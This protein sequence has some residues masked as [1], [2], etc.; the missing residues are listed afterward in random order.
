MRQRP[1]AQQRQ[2]G[3]IEQAQTDPVQQPQRHVGRV[4]KSGGNGG[5][6]DGHGSGFLVTSDGYLLTNAHVVADQGTVKVKFEQGF[7][8]D[9][10]VEKVN[11]DF[12]IALIKT[13]GSDMAA[14]TIG[15]DGALQLGEELFAIGTPLDE[16][17]GQTVTRGIMSGKREFEGRSF[18]QTD[19]S[20]NPGNSGGPL[21]D[22]T[23][24]V[25]GI[26]TL[27]VQETGVQ[28]IGFGV[29][30]SKALEMLNIEFLK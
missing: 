9:G 21:I 17:L 1:Y 8:L 15:D 23:G 14:L 29:P 11:R 24:K 12:D 16:K 10:T 2:R 13:P 25:V 18:L 3:S 7:T 26:A 5:N 22:E 30:M 6:K 28:G 4:G 20:I 27:K 19:V